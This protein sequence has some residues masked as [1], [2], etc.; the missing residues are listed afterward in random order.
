MLTKND[1]IFKVM[2]TVAVTS[3]FPLLDSPFV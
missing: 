2:S 3:K 1:K